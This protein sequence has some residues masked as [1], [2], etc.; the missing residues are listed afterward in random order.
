MVE[1]FCFHCFTSF[2]IN[3]MLCTMIGLLQ[4]LLYAPIQQAERQQYFFITK[5][6]K[7]ELNHL[8]CRKCVMCNAH[9]IKNAIK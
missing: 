7:S 2:L 8:M 4:L 9:L 6:Y 1:W 5:V 3:V